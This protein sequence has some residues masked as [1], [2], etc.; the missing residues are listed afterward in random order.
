MTGDADADWRGGERD[1]EGLRGREC[2]AEGR[3]LGGVSEGYALERLQL[4]NF[5]LFPD[6]RFVS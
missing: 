4:N 6:R 2:W 5:V 3:R 1:Q